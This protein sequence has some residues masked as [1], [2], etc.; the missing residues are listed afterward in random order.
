M[1]YLGNGYIQCH[2]DWERGYEF[3]VYGLFGVFPTGL[4][5]YLI[6]SVHEKALDNKYLQK[7]TN[8]MWKLQ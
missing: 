3:P 5:I 1:G 4:K 2:G 8:L 6:F 7:N